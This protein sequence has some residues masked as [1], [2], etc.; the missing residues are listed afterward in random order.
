MCLK[1]EI[2]SNVED[3]SLQFRIM[4]VKLVESTNLVESLLKLPESVSCN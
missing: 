1:L 2:I 3:S 4:F